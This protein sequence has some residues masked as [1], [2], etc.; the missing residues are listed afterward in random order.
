MEGV[1]SNT[2]RADSLLRDGLVGQGLSVPGSLASSV[3]TSRKRSQA[4]VIQEE[5]HVAQDSPQGQITPFDELEVKVRRVLERKDSQGPSALA[6]ILPQHMLLEEP[7]RQISGPPP[8]EHDYT[9]E[10]PQD[11]VPYD[12]DKTATSSRR[13]PYSDEGTAGEQGEPYCEEQVDES[14]QSVS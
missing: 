6:E 10:R 12:K 9:F 11:Q 5:P 14:R 8:G 1:N 13:G 7:D 3:P 2:T 4:A